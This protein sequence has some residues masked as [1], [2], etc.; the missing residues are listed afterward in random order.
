MV[1]LHRTS[2]NFSAV[3]LYQQWNKTKKIK[4]A[5]NPYETTE[6]LQLSVKALVCQG[7]QLDFI[8]RLQQIFNMCQSFNILL[9]Y[10]YILLNRTK[11]H[12]VECRND[13]QSHK[14]ISSELQN[15]FIEILH[16]IGIALL[17]NRKPN[18]HERQGRKTSEK[19]FK[20][21]IWSSSHKC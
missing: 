8:L 17:W 15:T 2:S 14:C 3:E 19:Y 4:K 1:R 18:H 9:L 21:L 7:I 11:T 5:Q 20:Y 6:L 16:P 10:K 13:M 12:S